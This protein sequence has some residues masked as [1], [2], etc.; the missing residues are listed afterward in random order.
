MAICEL[1][2]D[3]TQVAWAVYTMESGDYV[4]IFHSAHWNKERAK[5]MS[6]ILEEKTKIVK[7]ELTPRK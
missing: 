7:V 1:K 2:Y 5:L 4:W 3:K 6:Q